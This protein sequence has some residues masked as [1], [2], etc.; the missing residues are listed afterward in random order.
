MVNNYLLPINLIEFLDEFN[1]LANKCGY[2]IYKLR[3][4][5]GFTSSRRE[6]H[7][8]KYD[9][10]FFVIKCG[11]TDLGEHCSVDILLSSEQLMVMDNVRLTARRAFEKVNREFTTFRR[12]EGQ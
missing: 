7:A 2:T 6:L 10:A 5:R 11:P 4:D 8:E 1:G 9:V 3:C 12:R